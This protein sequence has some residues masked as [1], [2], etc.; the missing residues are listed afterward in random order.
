MH[1]RGRTLRKRRLD[2]ASQT[3]LA[4]AHQPECS[5]PCT[6]TNPRRRPCRTR[7]APRTRGSDGD[8]AAYSRRAV[9]ELS[10]GAW[11]SF[12]REE[13]GGLTAAAAGRTLMIRTFGYRD[14]DPI[15]L[16]RHA[17]RSR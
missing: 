7:S 11:P 10:S 12:Y 9:P 15:G 4:R 2:H 8:R 6:S 1:S 17:E 14:N 5:P 16:R 3:A 13:S